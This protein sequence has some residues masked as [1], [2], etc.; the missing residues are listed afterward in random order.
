LA[1]FP[2]VSPAG[3]YAHQLKRVRSAKLQF[4]RKAKALHS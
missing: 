3:V 1:F 2:L 4:C